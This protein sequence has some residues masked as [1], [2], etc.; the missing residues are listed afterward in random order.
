M[1]HPRSDL[2]LR[3]DPVVFSIKLPSLQADQKRRR[4]SRDG[5]TKSVPALRYIDICLEYLLLPY[6][7]R[8]EPP[9]TGRFQRS[10]SFCIGISLRRRPKRGS[11]RL[12]N[13]DRQEAAFHSL[14]ICETPAL[15]AIIRADPTLFHR[16]P[17]AC[18]IYFVAGTK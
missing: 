15:S 8:Y 10:P 1:R 16:S 6:R 12:Q 4:I 7:V 14:K 13:R 3:P 17:H 5:W 11:E 18:S 9:G 2:L